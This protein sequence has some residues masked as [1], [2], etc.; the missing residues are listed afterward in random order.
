MTKSSWQPICR[1]ITPPPPVGQAFKVEPINGAAGCVLIEKVHENG[2]DG[3]VFRLYVGANKTGWN[4][5]AVTYTPT[6]PGT[7]WI[8]DIPESNVIDLDQALVAIANADPNL[9]GPPVVWT[10]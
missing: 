8:V 1:K 9:P 3:V 6:S 7:F 10:P 5:A 2:A 4:T